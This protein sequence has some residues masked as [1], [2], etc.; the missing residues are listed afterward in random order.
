M[1][2][3]PETY[4]H[5]VISLPL[6]SDAL[7]RALAAPASP[8]VPRTT[9]VSLPPGQV[10][11]HMCPNPRPGS[12]RRASLFPEFL[13]MDVWGT[14]QGLAPR[15]PEQ[16]PTARTLV[17]LVPRLRLCDDV[18]VS[19]GPHASGSRP[20][21]RGAA[22]RSPMGGRFGGRP[23]L[24]AASSRAPASCGFSAPDAA[25]V[26][27]A[28]RQRR[29]GPSSSPI[30]CPWKCLLQFLSVAIWVSAF[31]VHVLGHIML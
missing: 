26:S 3:P 14:P 28:T 27:T 18:A 24:R 16:A 17:S 22:L 30:A 12:R 13:S 15:P 9:G 20:L 25:S 23:E 8:A 21:L 19:V 4:R 5:K 11:W 2:T 6:S 7:R 29:A 31:P 10:G 1:L